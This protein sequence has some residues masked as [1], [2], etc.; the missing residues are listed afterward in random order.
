LARVLRVRLVT[1]VTVIVEKVL[2]YIA[3]ALR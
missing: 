3:V 1:G 2:N